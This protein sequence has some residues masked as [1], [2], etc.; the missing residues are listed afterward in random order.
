MHDHI[1]QAITSFPLELTQLVALRV[2]EASRP[3]REEVASPKLL[4]ARVC[5]SLEPMEACSSG[6]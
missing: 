1:G 2:E 5:H 3:L 6:G 4:F